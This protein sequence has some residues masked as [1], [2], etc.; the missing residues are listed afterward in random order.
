MGNRTLGDDIEDHALGKMGV[1]TGS[2]INDLGLR[3][4]PSYESSPTISPV[5]GRRKPKTPKQEKSSFRWTMGVG[6]GIVLI[7]YLQE[8]LG[9]LPN[10]KTDGSAYLIAV[11]ATML[12]TMFIFRFVPYIAKLFAVAFLGATA[13]AIYSMVT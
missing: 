5:R 9:V 7:V 3:N 8:G 6:A 2:A 4:Q 13:I 11:G 12:V 1:S 10:V